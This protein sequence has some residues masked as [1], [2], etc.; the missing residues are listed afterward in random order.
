MEE[1]IWAQRMVD[2]ES[3]NEKVKNWRDGME[4]FGFSETHPFTFQWT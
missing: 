2:I 3:R 4:E 1:E